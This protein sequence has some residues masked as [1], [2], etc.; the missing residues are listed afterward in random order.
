MLNSDGTKLLNMWFM[1]HYTEVSQQGNIQS[2]YYSFETTPPLSI[3]VALTKKIA[4]IISEIFSA[5]MIK[6]PE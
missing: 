2:Q 1:P 5:V 4:D 6:I 3:H